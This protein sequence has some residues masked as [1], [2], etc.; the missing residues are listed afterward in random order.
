MNYLVHLYLQHNWFKA[1]I[2]E[3][4]K[5]LGIIKNLEI[6]IDILLIILLNVYLNKLNLIK[7]NLLINWKYILTITCK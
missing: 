2:L 3:F 1:I 6:E 5:I 4:D 7:C